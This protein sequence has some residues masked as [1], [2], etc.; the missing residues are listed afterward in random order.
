M[1]TGLS[2][3]ADAFVTGRALVFLHGRSQQGH[4]PEALRDAWTDGLN[5]GLDRLGYAAIDA[6]D[7]F[8]PYYGDRLAE[9]LR[10]QETL[11][12]DA[13]EAIAPASDSARELYGRLLDRAARQA[14]MPDAEAPQPDEGLGLTGGI[15]RL[16]RR[17]LDWLAQHSGLDRLVIASAFRDVALYLDEQRIR[18][19]VLACVRETV[20]ATGGIVLVAHSLG[21]V[22]AMDLLTARTDVTDLVTVGSPLGMDTVYDRLLTGGPHCP[23]RVSSWANAWAPADAVA[24]GCPLRDQW[25]GVTG[26]FSVD[27]PRDAAHDIDKYLAH[28][29]VAGAIAER[30]A[31]PRR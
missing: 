23:Q 17:P 4:A 28:P 3:R 22:V 9:V 13:P 21:T 29:E 6:A 16:T 15:V 30:L 18:D 8:F 12:A 24:I 26:E 14:G 5:Q 27:N 11:G 7:V 1:L 10:T 19:D 2:G 20:P 31:L 25:T